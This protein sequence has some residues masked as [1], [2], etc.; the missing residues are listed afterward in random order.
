VGSREAYERLIAAAE[1]GRLAALCDR[2]AV[3]VLTVFGSA[4]DEDTDPRDLDIAVKFS[5]TK[6]ADLLRLVEELAD[7]TGSGDID[8]MDLDRADPVARSIALTDCLPLFETADGD[9]VREQIRAVQ[10]RLDT[11]WLRAMELKRLAS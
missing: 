5:A 8:L 10:E 1:D 11:G 3:S 4:I 7:M 6:E 2:N 9:Y